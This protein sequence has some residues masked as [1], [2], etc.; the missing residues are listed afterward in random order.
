MLTETSDPAEISPVVQE[1]LSQKNPDWARANLEEIQDA[2]EIVAIELATLAEADD[3]PDRAYRR[4]ALWRTMISLLKAQAGKWAAAGSLALEQEIARTRERCHATP[5]E[6]LTFMHLY[7]EDLLALAAEAESE[8]RSA[9][10]DL[11]AMA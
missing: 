1:I 7:L 10:E 3:V 9:C 2:T 4:C 11:I 6:D 5:E 8:A